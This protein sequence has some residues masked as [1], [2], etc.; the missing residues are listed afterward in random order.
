MLKLYPV[1]LGTFFETHCRNVILRQKVMPSP[2][3]GL[4]KFYLHF[5]VIENLKITVL[6]FIRGKM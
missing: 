3:S 5:A 6:Y 4:S 1:K 2:N